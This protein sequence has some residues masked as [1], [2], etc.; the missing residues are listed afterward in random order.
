MYDTSPRFS[1]SGQMVDCLRREL[2]Y[3]EKRARDF[4]FEAIARIVAERGG[5]V[6]VSRMTRDAAA[7][8]RRAADAHG[9]RFDNWAIASRALVHAML[10]AGVLVAADGSAIPSD[11]AA[12]AAVVAGL[13]ERYADETEAFLLEF[14]IRR[15]GDIGLR[16]HTALAHALFRQ[17]D[18]SVPLED[19]EDRVAVLLATLADRVELRSGVYAVAGS[20]APEPLETT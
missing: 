10:A 12:Q 18:R 13:R 19:L 2:L 3:C 16:D 17:F 20:E 6:I 9:F 8:A 1:R 4:L 7:G 14:L 5:R 11:V 15:L